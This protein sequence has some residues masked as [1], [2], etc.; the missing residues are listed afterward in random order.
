MQQP[1]FAYWS[2]R[3]LAEPIRMLLVHLGVAFEDKHYT[4]GDAP[5]YDKSG[6]LA[7]KENLG[8]DFPNLPYFIDENVK[9]TESYAIITYIAAKYNPD[10]LGRTA[11][12]RVYV[13]MCAGVLKDVNHAVS[14]ACYAPDATTR[15]PI[16]LDGNKAN[17]GRI[18]NYLQGKRFFMG[19]QPTWV[20]FCAYELFDR[21]EAFD[22]EFLRG[23]SPIFETYKGH[24]RGLAHIEEFVS[25]P[26]LA[27][28]NKM[29][30]WGNSPL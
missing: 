7:D 26:R 23:I 22:P 9:I 5:D 18:A 2:I 13:N 15:I 28:N 6:W 27:F 12:E 10:F 8:L 21:I 29:A 11:Q 4:A 3:G 20:D 14:M 30:G 17:L 1:I 25:R 19:D 24:V 16:A